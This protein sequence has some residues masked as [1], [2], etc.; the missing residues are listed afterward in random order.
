MNTQPLFV[1]EQ[2]CDL[3]GRGCVLAPGPSIEEG[4]QPVRAGDPIRLVLPMGGTI[5]THIKSL[6]WLKRLVRPAVLTAPMLLPK[7]I[8]KGQV[9]VGT[10]VFLLADLE[11]NVPDRAAVIAEAAKIAGY[12]KAP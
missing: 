10:K 5:D 4:A 9:P 1:V 2:T 8:T 12:G 7:E 3:S 11:H 6:G